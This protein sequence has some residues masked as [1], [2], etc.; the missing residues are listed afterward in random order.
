VQAYDPYKAAREE[1]AAAI[2]ENGQPTGAY[3][4]IMG[5]H[6]ARQTLATESTRK[7][8]Q[9]FTVLA[10]LG[11]IAGVILGIVCAVELSHAAST[12]TTTDPFGFP[13]P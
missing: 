9:F 5:I 10:V 4:R 12:A 3:W 13:T 8:M 7:M 1:I 2:D 11:I 6:A